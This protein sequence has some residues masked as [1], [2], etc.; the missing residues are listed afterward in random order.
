[1]SDGLASILAARHAAASRLKSRAFRPNVDALFQLMLDD[2]RINRDANILSNLRGKVRNLLLRRGLRETSGKHPALY[3]SYRGNGFPLK[4][5]DLRRLPAW[6]F[7]SPWMR[8]QVATLVMAE[9]GYF[10]FKVHIH[11]DL[12]SQWLAAGKDLKVELRNSL[13]RH[14]K[15]AFPG[16]VP[17]FFFVLEDRTTGSDPTR[18]HAHGSIELRRAQLPTRGKGSRILACLALRDEKAARLKAGRIKTV[19]V[20]WAASGGKEPKV[21]ISTGI[22]QSRNVWHREPY[23]P[24]FNQQWVDYAFK[25]VKAVSATLGESRLAMH[26]PLL[27]E[28]KRLWQLVRLGEGAMRHW[29]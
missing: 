9:R 5:H 22:D 16:E 29:D 10:Q 15:R 1:M 11:D 14:L 4:T 23:G 6:R 2:K 26:Q 20:L 18:P 17:F 3:K 27:Q 28:A 25:N 21:A 13:A 12:R 24:F 7:L 19:G 8:V